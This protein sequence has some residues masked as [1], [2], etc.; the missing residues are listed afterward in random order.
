[1]K[2]ILKQ[3]MIIPKKYY[4]LTEKAMEAQKTLLSSLFFL[5]S[6]VREMNP[7]SR[8][9]RRWIP[10]GEREPTQNYY[11][12]YVLFAAQTLMNG[13]SLPYLEEYTFELHNRAM[14]LYSSFDNLFQAIYY[15]MKFSLL[16]PYTDLLSCLCDF[17]KLWLLFEKRLY[18]CYHS[19]FRIS[20]IKSNQVL[21]GFQKFMIKTLVYSVKKNY[22]TLDMIY[23]YDPTLILAL[24]RLTFVYVIYHQSNP[25]FFSSFPWF[26][27]ERLVEIDK[28]HQ[29]FNLLNRKSIEKLE[30]YLVHGISNV[31]SS[32]MDKEITS[33][34]VVPYTSLP[35]N[36]NTNNTNN[37]NN[38][39]NNNKNNKLLPSINSTAGK[40][41]QEQESSNPS[42]IIEKD[43]LPNSNS[44]NS[45]K[46]SNDTSII[47][48]DL[49]QSEMNH[50]PVNP[51]SLLSPSTVPVITVETIP[52]SPS[53][54]FQL[55]SPPLSPTTT[56][57]TPSDQKN[58]K[59][60]S[61]K[62]KR[63]SLVNH[64][65][66]H[67]SPQ[68]VLHPNDSFLLVPKR[69]EP[70]DETG[71]TKEEDW[72]F[73]NDD[74]E[75]HCL[76]SPEE[77]DEE[78]EEE[79]ELIGDILVRKVFK[80]V[81]QIVDEFQSS[82]E[83]RQLNSIMKNVFVKGIEKIQKLQAEEEMR[84]NNNRQGRNGSNNKNKER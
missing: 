63:L 16:P 77:V 68:P 26:S 64:S 78:E 39:N 59:I 40:T 56:T 10:G 22:F 46:G 37:N 11:S 53:S 69:Y 70:E 6:Q 79:E 61:K 76:F 18:I 17:D 67:L 14:D 58:N 27:K 19:V 41:S 31:P 50:D 20:R 55:I 73:R 7:H 75:N 43:P 83:S 74:D 62:G 8:S 66:N 80:S 49:S 34:M 32:D 57:T 44:V 45:V 52:T 54:S 60:Q 65:E 2:S 29:T 9:Y 51:P 36:T 24:P 48:E 3:L 84:N 71:S 47:V 13:A 33:P 23:E 82:E 25:F 12:E 4:R 30:L 5:L 15:R 35:G 42:I 1:M 38:N 81:C 28:L 21:S 72:S